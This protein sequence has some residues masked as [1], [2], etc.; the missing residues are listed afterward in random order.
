MPLTRPLSPRSVPTS[1]AEGPG[2]ETG[3]AQDGGAALD[4][5]PEGVKGPVG[6]D[7]APARPA[8]TSRQWD[9]EAA[10]MA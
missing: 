9:Q 8:M 5:Q 2:A 3:V 10:N 1:E 6:A 7:E 4:V